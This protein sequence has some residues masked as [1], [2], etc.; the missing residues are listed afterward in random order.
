MSYEHKIVTRYDIPPC[1][2]HFQIEIW[3][4][5][6]INQ[7]IHSCYKSKFGVCHCMKSKKF[8]STYLV[9]VLAY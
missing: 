2:T 1:E 8:K 3:S 9:K 7:E 5:K 4:S 6:P